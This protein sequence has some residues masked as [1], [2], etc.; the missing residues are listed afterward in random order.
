MNRTGWT[1]KS[2]RK[3]WRMGNTVASLAV[4]LVPLMMCVVVAPIRAQIPEAQTAAEV[5]AK[6]GYDAD[7]IKKIQKGEIVRNNL[8][9]GAE[10]E[11][12]GTVVAVFNL[13]VR[14][15]AD[16]ALNARMLNPADPTAPF[17][18]WSPEADADAAFEGLGFT[19]KESREVRRFLN[20]EPGDELNLSTAEISRFRHDA[21]DLE[22]V[23]TTLR[24]IL[25]E[26]YEDY[27][28]R[29]LGGTASY[30]RGEHE[31]SSPGEELRL[32]INETMTAARQQDF[33]QSLLSYP[34]NLLAGVQHRFYWFKQLVQD[35]PTFILAHRA[36]FRFDDKASLVTEEQ[37]YVGH[38]Y[39]AN[40]IAGA[41]L[42]VQDGTVVFYVNRSF[43]DQVAG[44]ASG[45]KR[46]IGRKQM[47]SEVAAN[48]KAIR[49]RLKANK[50]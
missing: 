1:T 27:R 19:P 44:F 25:K 33:F 48:L 6:L 4:R 3:G 40:F 43:T 50:S 24:A 12:A 35:R 42:A 23:N 37:Y 15:L 2:S 9:E 7:Q 46:S 41:C 26:R 20:P 36:E 34:T 17:R 10:N 22:S 13:P 28:Q 30:Q 11:L 32:A 29:G 47:L 14:D 45:M 21:H 31:F 8:K 5:A 38:S 16:A 39:N 49:D 18:G